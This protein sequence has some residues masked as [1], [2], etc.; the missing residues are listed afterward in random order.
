M[1]TFRKGLRL[2]PYKVSRFVIKCQIHTRRTFDYS[3][4]MIRSFATI[5][6]IKL[7]GISVLNKIRKLANLGLA[8]AVVRR[9]VRT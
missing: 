9:S 1:G 7:S 6:D 4:I 2:P 8:E 5:F 3:L